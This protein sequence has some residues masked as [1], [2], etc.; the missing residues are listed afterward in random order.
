MD[1]RNLAEIFRGN[2]CDITPESA[3]IQVEGKEDKMK[4]VFR[5]LGEYGIL[6]VA[7]TGRIAIPRESGV[8]TRYLETRQLAKLY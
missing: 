3:T 1:L 2:I 7:R 5:M 6:E 8:N 4:A